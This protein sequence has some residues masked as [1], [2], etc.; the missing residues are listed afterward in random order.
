[1]NHPD[2]PVNITLRLYRAL[3]AAFPYEFQNLARGAKGDA[4]P[5]L[6]GLIAEWDGRYQF[7]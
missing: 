7:T 4:V 1:M 2:R 5:R 6:E 3:A